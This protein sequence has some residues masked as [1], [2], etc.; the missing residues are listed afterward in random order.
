MIRI[1]AI[2]FLLSVPLLWVLGCG[3]VRKETPNP[4]DP[5]TVLGSVG[6]TLVWAGTICAVAGL[7]LSVL[8][9]F[10]PALRFLAKFMPY[11]GIAGACTVGIGL[12]YLYVAQHSWL[13]L[14]AGG[15]VAVGVGWWFWPR[16][17]RAVGRRLEG[18]V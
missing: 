7:A 15:V 17:H 6:V 9:L 13:L 12:T 3:E 16:I 1:V 2:L 8:S 11:V 4:G 10:V 18:K 5:A 14:L